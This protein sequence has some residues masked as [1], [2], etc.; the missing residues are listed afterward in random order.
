MLQHA[1]RTGNCRRFRKM[2]SV[3]PGLGLISISQKRSPST[4][5]SIL[6]RPTSDMAAVIRCTTAES[7][8]DMRGAKRAGGVL[9]RHSDTADAALATTIARYTQVWWR[10]CRQPEKKPPPPCRKLFADS[11]PDRGCCELARRSDVSA[12]GAAHAFDQPSVGLRWLQER[13]VGKRNAEVSA[14]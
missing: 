1:A 14:K 11:K 12:A 4:R 2:S 5:K 7:K 6:L 3:A 8:S 13:N 9:R 10:S